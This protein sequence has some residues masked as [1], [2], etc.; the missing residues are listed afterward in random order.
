MYHEVDDY[1]EFTSAPVQ[2]LYNL[3]AKPLIERYKAYNADKLVVISDST[4]SDET[5]VG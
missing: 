5:S 2:T 1:N 4:C 3:I